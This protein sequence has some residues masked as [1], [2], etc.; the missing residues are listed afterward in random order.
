VAHAVTGVNL[1]HHLVFFQRVR[2][3]GADC[4]QSSLVV[5]AACT[6]K[7]F[8][9]YFLVLFPQLEAIKQTK[10]DM[11]VYLGNYNLP[12]DNDAAYN[13]Q[14]QAI[15]DVIATYGTDH[16][17]GI[18]VGNEYMLKYVVVFLSIVSYLIHVCL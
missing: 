17:A 15:K 10:V 3:Y 5:S 7:P 9:S 6:H 13:R 2:L 1:Q 16:I 11:Q 4:N 18:T 14:K 12:T 8:P